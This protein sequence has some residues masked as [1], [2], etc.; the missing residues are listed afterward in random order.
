[1]NKRIKHLLPALGLSIVL[2]AIMLILF[3]FKLLD[4]PERRLFD[5]RL[6]TRG[7]LPYSE[8]ITI[9]VIDNESVMPD[10]LGRW[11]WP[12][13]YQA[14][15]VEALNEYGAKVIGFDIFFP[16][17]DDNVPLSGIRQFLLAGFESLG[18]DALGKSRNFMKNLEIFYKKWLGA[19]YLAPSNEE[20]NNKK[21][22][23]EIE[24][25]LNPDKMFAAALSQYDN[26]I[27]G[28]Y[29]TLSLGIDELMRNLESSF[30]SLKEHFKKENL[31][32]PEG[33]KL[34]YKNFVFFLKK[35]GR[36]EKENIAYSYRLQATED[37]LKEFE[38]SKSYSLS[39]QNYSP[40]IQKSV[41]SFYSFV[42]ANLDQLKKELTLQL[43][44]PN[45]EIKNIIKG[46]ISGMESSAIPYESPSGAVNSFIR[47]PE[48]TPN[49]PLFTSST[50]HFGHV[51][52]KPDPDGV[53][54]YN[55]AGISIGN[56]IF[57]SLSLK[58]AALYK[59][60]PMK[61]ILQPSG[62]PPKLYLGDAEIPL[63]EK[64]RIL[65]NYH[66][67]KRY[68]EYNIFYI[69]RPWV[70]QE[71]MEESI[72]T[73]FAELLKKSPEEYF[74]EKY[75]R[76]PREGEIEE[77]IYNETIDDIPIASHIIQWE[78]EK[79]F[80]E[81]YGK[82]PQ[83]A[84][85]DK[86]V[87]IGATAT[88]VYDMR[89]TPFSEDYPGVE[90]HAQVVDSILK[91]KFLFRPSFATLYGI[92]LIVSL[93]LILGIVI[94][95][96]SALRGAVLLILLFGGLACFDF[97]FFFNLKGWWMPFVYPALQMGAVYFAV[98]IYRYA[99]EEREKRFIKDTFG[100]Y[101]APSVVEV[102]TKNPEMVKLGGQ[103][104]EMTAFFSDIRGFST[105]SE[106]LGD[107]QLL[108]E[109][110][111]DY[112]S[113]MAHVIEKYEG[114][115]DKYEGDAI[116]AF[117]GAPVHFP[118][119]AVKACF[120]CL[121]QQ[122]KLAELRAKWK[123][124]GRWPS[125]VYNARVRMGLNTGEMVVGN[126]GSAGRMNYT[127][128]GDA[129][130]LAS[131]LEG[132]NKP[133]GTYI[134]ISEFTYKQ[135]RDFIEVRELDSLRVVGK[136]KPVKVYELLARKGELSA[137]KLRVVEIFH[138]GLDAYKQQKWDIAIAR[139]T[140]ALNIDPSDGPSK[141]YIARCEEF[142]LS[143]PPADWDGVYTLE[144]K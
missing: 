58:A 84:F 8:N 68:S 56:Y 35:M 119:H 13:A 142:K 65:I 37:F 83:E 126:M 19:E 48:L 95:L 67:G 2:S 100:R 121:D 70:I 128:M 1:M 28:Y 17:P 60:Q 62:I 116:I 118:D 110:L 55:M 77:M 45:E 25:K 87:L 132:A 34:D 134:M 30:R 124:E 82:T 107:P 63:D 115:I 27:L 97:F 143:P 4:G 104:L 85:Q 114:T 31:S 22:E 102:L 42:E 74:T 78:S 54:R 139:F 133:Y 41:K 59:R 9:A 10:Q 20:N 86:I 57:P 112:L 108:V 80:K 39:L 129:V 75:S 122:I 92:A 76:A 64:G 106:T 23:D 98:T 141:T 94:P 79:L 47:A 36:F 103:K 135:A 11:P 138:E 125:I 44:S 16:E 81:I 3:W 109:L 101:L 29:F 137:Q 69:I 46:N 140:E 136:S 14:Y 99:T 18:L 61:I 52:V 24:K 90:I 32:V 127:I 123:N 5:W 51:S 49:I 144:S 120:A 96:I 40:D 91:N 113:A 53:I 105:I 21:E 130:N 33:I 88:G 12:R 131:R 26:I 117:W 73:Y 72:P 15:L 71:P 111:N 93:A 7:Q 43:E 66:G 50:N 6:K 38:K 89:V